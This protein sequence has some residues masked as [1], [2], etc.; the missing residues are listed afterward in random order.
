[1]TCAIMAGGKSSRIGTDKALLLYKNKTLLQHVIDKVS[2]IFENSILISN[3][4]NICDYYHIPVFSDILKGI[5]PL[6]G[7]HAALTYASSDEVCI[8]P[9]DM[10]LI[11][12][13]MLRYL[14][15][16]KK[17]YRNIIY[18]EYGKP[19]P[20]IGIYSKSLHRVIQ[21]IFL[22]LG[23]GNNEKSTTLKLMELTKYEPF[24]IIEVTELDW[25]KPE[26]FFNVNTLEDLERLRST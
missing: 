21:S 20:L 19:Q 9:C 16:N 13:K 8:V 10:P 1:M 22:Q 7:L 2:N 17:E 18:C 23:N 11:E 5:G 12:D 4:R 26:L 3:N 15:E 6:G 14:F 24:K 25:Y